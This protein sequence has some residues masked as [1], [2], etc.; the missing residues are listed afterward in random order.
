MLLRAFGVLPAVLLPAWGVLPAV[1]LCCCLHWL[2]C[3]LL[4]QCTYTHSVS[5]G[6]EVHQLGMVPMSVPNA[7]TYSA[8]LIALGGLNTASLLQKRMSCI[9]RINLLTTTL[10]GA[11]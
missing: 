4:A 2:Y 10:T 8:Y 6:E 9:L 5:Q 3:Q 11:F 7:I 1:L